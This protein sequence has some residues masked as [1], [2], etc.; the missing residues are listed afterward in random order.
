M[1]FGYV[2]VQGWI[3][4]PNEYSFFDQPSKI[5]FLSP[6]YTEVIKCNAMTC[7]GT[8]VIYVGGT[9]GAL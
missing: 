3:I 4:D 2:L 8:V 7:D 5:L 6:H 1:V 9:L